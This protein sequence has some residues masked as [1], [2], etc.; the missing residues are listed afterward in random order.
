M[1]KINTKK[2]VVVTT[3]QK[4]APT[5][6]RTKSSSTPAVRKGELIFGKTNYILMF[7]GIGLIALGLLLMSGGAM[8][9]PDVW[10]ESII[11]STRRT[12][13][14]PIVIVIGLI[15]EIVAIFRKPGTD[16]VGEKELLS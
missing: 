3:S 15:V 8:P 12:L 13:L 14:A 4:T 9:S 5:V 11:F 10:D 6:S 1:S 7:A 16:S 2:K